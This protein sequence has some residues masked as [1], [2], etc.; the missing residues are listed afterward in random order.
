MANPLFK[1]RIWVRK[2]LLARLSNFSD[3]NITKTIDTILE[4]YI[5]NVELRQ[6]LQEGN[7]NE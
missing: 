4:D 7:K 2:D 1:T 6:L 3:D 5:T